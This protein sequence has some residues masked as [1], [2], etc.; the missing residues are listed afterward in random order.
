MGEC[1]F[2]YVRKQFLVSLDSEEKMDSETQRV[3]RKTL[4]EPEL[5]FFF[6]FQEEVQE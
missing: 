6:G 3:R 5:I 4:E 1:F 2:L